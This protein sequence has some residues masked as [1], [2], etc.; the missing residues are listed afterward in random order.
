MVVV[1]VFFFPQVWLIFMC[2]DNFGVLNLFLHLNMFSLLDLDLI[3]S[4]HADLHIVSVCYFDSASRLSK[5]RVYFN[6]I[7]ITFIFVDHI[8]WNS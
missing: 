1:D 5:H 8:R 7:I 6:S 2:S 4:L 3:C